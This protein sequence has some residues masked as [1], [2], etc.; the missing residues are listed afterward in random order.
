MITATLTFP[1][2]LIRPRFF[3][4]RS[5]DFGFWVLTWVTPHTLCVFP[6][7]VK[8]ISC[9]TF[10][11]AFHE[12]CLILWKHIRRSQLPINRLALLIDAWAPFLV[13]L[14][15]GFLF[16]W[17]YQLNSES[18]AIGIEIFCICTY[19]KIYHLLHQRF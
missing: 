7:S 8:Q 16:H 14:I 12:C 1:T 2:N 5:P 11:T 15:P 19:I 9:P 13:V 10:S 18:R 17:I 3:P 6:D 4:K